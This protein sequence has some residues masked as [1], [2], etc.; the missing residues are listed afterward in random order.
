MK[1]ILMGAA[2]AAFLGSAASAAPILVS[3][4]AVPAAHVSYAD[5]NL[6]SAQGRARLEGR[7]RGAAENLCAATG[8]RTIEAYLTARVCYDAA[9]ASGLR[10]MNDAVHQQASASSAMRRGAGE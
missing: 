8:D 4:N 5:I 6:A 9:V 1:R 7:I 3:V 10:Q 2:T